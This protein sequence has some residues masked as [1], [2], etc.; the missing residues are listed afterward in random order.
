MAICAMNPALLSGNVRR[1][2]GRLN[3][4]ARFKID[5]AYLK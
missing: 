3:L 2:A 4:F 1:I 5:S